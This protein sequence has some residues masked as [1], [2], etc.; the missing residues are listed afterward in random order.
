M[1]MKKNKIVLALSVF[2]FTI[3]C[4]YSS[5]HAASFG[6]SGPSGES[7][8]VTASLSKP[9][10][11]PGEQVRA[12]GITI[13]SQSPIIG[14][15][16]L[17]G[18]TNGGSANLLLSNISNGQTLTNYSSVVI[19]T[20]PN[21]AGTYNANFTAAL[22]TNPIVVYSSAGE[23]GIGGANDTSCVVT[24]SL[25]DGVPLNQD[26]EAI[27]EV[28]G[29]PPQHQNLYYPP[30]AL[31]TVQLTLQSGQTQSP[32]ARTAAEGTLYPGVPAW[33]PG[34]FFCLPGETYRGSIIDIWP[35]EIN[36]R[37]VIGTIE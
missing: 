24:I 19:G 3:L 22:Y 14:Q 36:G 27:V 4:M 12:T 18:G 32:V 17:D 6:L 28:F 35:A 1:Y 15:V 26:I 29:K 10:Y 21:T 25:S 33:A 9:S 37:S 34:G 31:G 2:S 11:D 20:A 23:D 7:I 5:V 16:S 13:K 8:I 30:Q